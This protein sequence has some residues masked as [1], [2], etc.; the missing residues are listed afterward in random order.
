LQLIQVRRALKLGFVG[1]VLLLVISWYFKGRLVDSTEIDPRLRTEP[2]Q[3]AT[4]EREFSF[5]YKG[6]VCHTKP[7]A[8][9]ELWGLVV[10]HNN[11]ESMADLVHDS[12]SVDTKDLCV[13]WGSNVESN[14]F[15]QVDYKSGQFTCYFRYPHGTKFNHNDLGNNHLITDQQSIRDQIAGVRVGDQVRLEGLLVNYQMDDW[16]GFWRNTSTVRNDAGCEVLFVREVD[17]L[18]QGTPF[19]YAAFEWGRRLLILLPLAYLI[20]FWLEARNPETSRVGEL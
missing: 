9:F 10:S 2:K 16:E 3:T 7:V 1:S 15:Q 4:R 14:D 13:I 11:I 8:N 12:T 20:V 19:W 18:R 6:R 17:V 5:E